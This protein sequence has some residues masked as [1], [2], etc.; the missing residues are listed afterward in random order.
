MMKKAESDPS[1]L[2]GPEA[3]SKYLLE[4]PIPKTDEQ[5]N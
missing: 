2:L 3:Y 4:K 1:V 5:I